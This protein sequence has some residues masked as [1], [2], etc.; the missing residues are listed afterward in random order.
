MAVAIDTTVLCLLFDPNIKPPND[1]T[2][3]KPVERARE[4]IEYLVEQLQTSGTRVLIPTPV[5][6]EFLVMAD[7]EG[8]DYLTEISNRSVFE[9]A[10]FDAISAVEA[11][12][13]QRK[14][15]KVGNKKA[16]LKGSRQCLKADR[17]I[18]GIAK[19]RQV[20]AIYTSDADVQKIA[21]DAKVPVVMLWELPLPPEDE[22]RLQ[23][24]GE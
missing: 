12:V 11:A 10:P 16:D 17:Q 14:A 15:T 24:E 18:V 6:A 5:L 23:F 8:P 9:I 7:A 20:D 3:G 1:P 19:T 2:T 4:R 22:P 21:I 13:L